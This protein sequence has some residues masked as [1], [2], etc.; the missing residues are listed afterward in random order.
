MV[1]CNPKNITMSVHVGAYCF[2]PHLGQNFDAIFR[3]WLQLRQLLA[4]ATCVW[5]LN[6]SVTAPLGL[7]V[8]SVSGSN[9]SLFDLFFT[10]LMYVINRGTVL[11]FPGIFT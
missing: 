1:G 2:E 4:D 11:F 8:S 9:S 7:K 6:I 5:S 3:G 10:S